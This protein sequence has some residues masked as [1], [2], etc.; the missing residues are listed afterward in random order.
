MFELWLVKPCREWCNHRDD[1]VNSVL[2]MTTA[3]RPKAP[4]PPLRS[5]HGGT[6]D[7]VLVVCGAATGS[8]SG[9]LHQGTVVVTAGLA[10]LSAELLAKFKPDC[11]LAPLFGVECDVMDIAARLTQLGYRGLLLAVS[12]PLPN[13]QAIR[14]EIQAAN[15]DL[16]FDL[17]EGSG[18]DPC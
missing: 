7:H 11:V 15:P 18:D 4:T 9:I 17:I 5:A 6:F 10:D 3:K 13:P 2:T 1:E 16:T 14:A 8:A 12:D